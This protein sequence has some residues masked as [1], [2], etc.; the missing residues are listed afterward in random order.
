MMTVNVFMMTVKS[1]NHFL[2]EYILFYKIE[3]NKRAVSQSRI[4]DVITDQ[5]EMS[6]NSSPSNFDLYL[7]LKTL[8]QNDI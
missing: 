3:D 6:E 4:K 8:D 1:Q 7:W 2:K 5:I